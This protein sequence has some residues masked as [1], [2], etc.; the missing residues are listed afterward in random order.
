MENIIE[1]KVVYFWLQYNFKCSDYYYDNNSI[2]YN[3]IEFFEKIVKE[4]GYR[5]ADCY[6]FSNPDDAKAFFEEMKSKCKLSVLQ[7]TNTYKHLNVELIV[8]M[9]SLEVEK[10]KIDND[11]NEDFISSK[12][13]EF[14]TESIT[15]NK[16]YYLEVSST[17]V[18]LLKKNGIPFSGSEH[19]SSVNDTI[20]IEIANKDKKLVKTLLKSIRNE[21]KHSITP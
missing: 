16:P 2:R 17:E 18:Q 11:G 20:V 13:I 21:N 5:K 9:C 3:S 4:N 1:K 12:V 14:Y 15:F 10:Y 8:D 19:C 6:T 7:S